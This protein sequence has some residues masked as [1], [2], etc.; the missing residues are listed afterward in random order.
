MLDVTLRPWHLDS[1]VQETLSFDIGL[2]PMPTSGW[3]RGKAALKALQYGAAGLSTIGS[4]TE[5]NERIL[6]TD[7]CTVLCRTD[8]EWAEALQRLIS[9]PQLRMRLGARG[10]AR[11]ID[12]Y[13]IEAVAPRLIELLR[14]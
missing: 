8:D 14:E 5:T 4:W 2:M 6:G 12:Q 3:S 10:R 13:S 1:E 11:V 7:A 9:D